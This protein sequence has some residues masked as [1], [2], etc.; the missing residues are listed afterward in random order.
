[1]D[2]RCQ[3]PGGWRAGARR[4]EVRPRKKESAVLEIQDGRYGLLLG[5]AL[6][7]CPERPLSVLLDREVVDVGAVRE[8]VRGIGDPHERSS[9]HQHLLPAIELLS[10]RLRILL[11]L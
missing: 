4:G 8:A 9:L 5:S 3:H 7:D 1:M 2:Q 10:A 11:T 6:P